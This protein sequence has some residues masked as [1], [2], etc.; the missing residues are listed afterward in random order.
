MLQRFGATHN[1]KPFERVHQAPYAGKIVRFGEC[2]LAR[3]RGQTKGKPRWLRALWSGKSEVSDTHIV[4]ISAGKLLSARSIRRTALEYD[5][6]LVA[7]LRDSPN[8]QSSFLAGRVGASRS[9][10]TPK[11]VTDQELG[12]GSEIAASDP[13]TV[14]DD[15]VDIPPAESSCQCSSS[16]YCPCEW[17]AIAGC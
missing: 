17:P 14:N 1:L 2:V 4:C 7:A 9:Q 10:V 8:Q 6:C 11:P 13:D 12:S 3:V 16:R 5:A 15:V